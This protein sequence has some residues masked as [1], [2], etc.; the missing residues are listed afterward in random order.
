MTGDGARLILTRRPPND[1]YAWLKYEDDGHEFEA[2]LAQVKL[3]SL[4]EG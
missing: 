2:D 4:L 3:I 1:G